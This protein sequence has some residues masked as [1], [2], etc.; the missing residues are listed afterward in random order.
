MKTVSGK[1]RFLLILGGGVA[2]FTFMSVITTHP[3]LA[4][5]KE[6]ASLFRTVFGV[7]ISEASRL[8][9]YAAQCG[10]GSFST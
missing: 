4:L 6:M 5:K 7:G 3:A 10:A 9:A 8:L 2:A 1:K